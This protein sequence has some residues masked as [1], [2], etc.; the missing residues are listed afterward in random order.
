VRASRLQV[1]GGTY[2]VTA[3]GNR[4]APIYEDEL[5]RTRFL[6]I[7]RDVVITRRWKCHFYCLMTNHYH[8]LLTTQL[9]D[10]AVGMHALNHV[11]AKTFNRRHRY[12]GHL[13]ER[14]YFSVLVE[15]ESHLMELVRYLALNPVRGGMCTNALDWRWSSYA[16]LVGT[17]QRPDFLTFETILEAFS[18]D[19]EAA[20]VML[21]QFVETSGCNEAA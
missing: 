11:Y 4:R 3:R 2:H 16:A 12:T 20:R 17:C 8:L 7:L 13:F 5:D 18:H 15:R 10:L 6:A 1:A 21:Q 9:A 19:P 14:R